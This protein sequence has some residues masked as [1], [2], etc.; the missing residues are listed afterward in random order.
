VT[1]HE[2]GHQFWYGLVGTNEFE[3]AWL[4]EGFNS[5]HDEKAAQIA[6]GPVGWGHRYFGMLDTS[7]RSRAPIPVMAPGVWLRRGDSE[8]ASLRKSGAF[9]VMARPAWGYRNAD[10]YTVNAY[11]KPALSLQTLEGFVGDDIMTRILRTYARRYRFAHPTSEDFI[12][13]VNEV[14]GRDYRWF[15]DQTWFSAEECDYAIAVRNTQ[16]RVM[17]GYAEGADGRPELVP[18][19]RDQRRKDEGPFDSEVIVRRLGGVRLPVEVRVE[20]ADGRV[21]Y[22]TWDGQYRWMRLR[23]HGPFKVR[24]AEV[25]PYGKIALDI[26]PGNN[27]WVDDNAPVA[28]RA[29]SKWAMRWM[30]WLQNLLELQTLL[31]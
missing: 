7:R 17:A 27:S 11:T 9:D 4:D 8:V 28:R 2:C 25:D 19:A 10:S 13:V 30:F 22:E 21:T 26:D 18:P 12:A 16:A 3:E 5:Y 15:F 6:L 31:G 29:A 24:A 23:Y 20:F 1:I 14:T